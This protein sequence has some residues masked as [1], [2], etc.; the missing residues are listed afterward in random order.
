MTRPVFARAIGLIS[1]S[2]IN[3]SGLSRVD[4]FCDQAMMRCARLVPNKCYGQNAHF[5]AQGLS[6][7]DP[8][9]R[10]RT[11]R[12]RNLVV[13]PSMRSADPSSRKGHPVS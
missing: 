13:M 2:C 10:H 9:F 6:G 12:P 4:R 8:L 5:F 11:L 3:V 7:A 1:N